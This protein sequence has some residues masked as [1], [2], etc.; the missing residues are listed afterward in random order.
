MPDTVSTAVGSTRVDTASDTVLEIDRVVSGYGE[1]EILHE[2]SLTVGA[3]EIVALIG[4]NGAGKTTLM[5]TLAGLLKV[6]SGDVRLRGESLR[7]A[8][9]EQIVRHGVSLVPEGRHVFSGMTVEDNLQ[10]GAYGLPA[11]KRRG[12]LDET[13]ERFPL[14]KERAKQDAGSLSG[15]QQQLLVVARALMRSPSVL[16]LDEPSLG[17]SPQMVETVFEVIGSLRATG[18]SVLLVEQNVTAGLELADRA[19]VLESGSIARSGT[20]AELLA[21]PS[22]SSSFLGHSGE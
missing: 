16:L 18:V 21:D 9:S 14:L 6:R 20:S 3:S 19:Y 15:G 13:L 10:I 11:A 22:L 17:L 4:S 2:V 8:S 7:R 1:L 5:K 12:S